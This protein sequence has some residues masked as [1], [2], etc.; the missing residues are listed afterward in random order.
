MTAVVFLKKAYQLSRSKQGLE[1]IPAEDHEQRSFAPTDSMR[2]SNIRASSRTDSLLDND[3][4]SSSSAN[5]NVK[6]KPMVPTSSSA[7]ELAHEKRMEG[8]HHPA[9]LPDWTD[10]EVF[11]KK[12]GNKIRCGRTGVVFYTGPNKVVI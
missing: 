1:Y 6:F 12:Y 11:W 4:D 3:D 7:P 8:D 2:R 10:E 5:L 9:K